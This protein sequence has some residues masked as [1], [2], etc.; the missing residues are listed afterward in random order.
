MRTLLKHT[1][2]GLYFQGPDRWTDNPEHAYDFRFTGR[3]LQYVAT[4]DLTEVE[5]A[6]EFEDAQ[7]VTTASLAL[8][9]AHYAT[10]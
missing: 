4:W 3:A 10:A 2:T 5:L 7:M 6:F 9:T 1:R 8:A